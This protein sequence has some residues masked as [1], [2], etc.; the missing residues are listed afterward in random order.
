MNHIAR[1]PTRVRSVYVDGGAPRGDLESFTA[2]GDETADPGRRPLVEVALA[3]LWPPQPGV[4][5]LAPR[6]EMRYR[7]RDALSRDWALAGYSF[8]HW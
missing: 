3:H 7:E 2:S 4:A 6:G 8:W 5:A 1:T